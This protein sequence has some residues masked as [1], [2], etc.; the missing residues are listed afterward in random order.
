MS[1]LNH[2]IVYAVLVLTIDER[3]YYENREHEA[4]G[5]LIQY[6]VKSNLELQRWNLTLP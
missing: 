3:D 1:T 5:V 2:M 6:F 4:A